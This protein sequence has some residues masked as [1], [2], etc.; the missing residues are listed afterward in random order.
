[1]R[2]TAYLYVITIRYPRSGTPSL[3]AN[4]PDMIC[5]TE[6]EAQFIVKELRG[7]VGV[8]SEPVIYDYVKTPF[9]EV[10]EAIRQLA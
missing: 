4:N 3:N 5:R 9:I 6:E 1:M 10:P 2:P 7:L 8:T